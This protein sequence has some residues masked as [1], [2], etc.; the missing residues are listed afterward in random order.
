MYRN[1]NN[2][3][4]RANGCERVDRRTTSSS[5]KIGFSKFKREENSRGK[6]RMCEIVSHYKKE[7]SKAVQEWMMSDGGPE[8][9]KL[10]LSSAAMVISRKAKELGLGPEELGKTVEAAC[11]NIEN[12]SKSLHAKNAVESAVV[13]IVLEQNE[14]PESVSILEKTGSKSEITGNVIKLLK[15]TE[16]LGIEKRDINMAGLLYS[17]AS[18]KLKPETAV[19]RVLLNGKNRVESLKLISEKIVPQATEEQLKML[20]MHVK[21]FKVVMDDPLEKLETALKKRA[22]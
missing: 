19:L 6:V 2:Y 3:Y 21:L 8:G 18:E 10:E 11:E 9:E 15:E 4:L 20:E 12:A 13:G 5:R 1:R 16:K 17:A 22:V 14:I 7:H